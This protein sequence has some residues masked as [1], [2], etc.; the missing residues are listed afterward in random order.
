MEIGHPFSTLSLTQTAVV[1]NMPHT[2][3]WSNGSI[4]NV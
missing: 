3:A 4:L 2:C 1:S